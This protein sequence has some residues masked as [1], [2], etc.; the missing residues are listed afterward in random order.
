MKLFGPQD[1]FL[2]S[3]KAVA[4]WEI[5]AD[6]EYLVTV[7]GLG[8]SNTELLRA[9]PHHLSEMTRI[10]KQRYITAVIIAVVHRYRGCA[11]TPKIHTSSSAFNP[12]TNRSR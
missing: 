10:Y 12:F 9:F 7:D 1:I 11:D 3:A 5:Q 2:V 4:G 8:F 6:D